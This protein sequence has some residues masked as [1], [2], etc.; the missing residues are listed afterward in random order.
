MNR[1]TI[2]LIALLIV[3]GAIVIFFLPSAQERESSDKNPEINFAIDS[4]SVMKLDMM[5]SGMSLTIENIGG[6]WMITSPGRYPADPLSVTQ[7]LHGLT[8]FKI[9]SIISSNPDKQ[10]LFQVD[11]S[12][13]QIT[14]TERSGKATSL[15]IGKMGPSFTE[16]Y[17]RLPGSRDVYLAEGLDTWS[18]SKELKEWRDKTILSVPSEAVN[19]LTYTIGA[20]QY[21]FRKDSA[22][23]KSGDGAVESN[24]INPPLTSL[25]NLRADDFVDSSMKF[26]NA[27]VTVAV[28]GAE[29]VQLILSPAVS[30][31]SKFFVQVSSS[32]QI[33][34]VSKY[35]AQQ[36]LKPI[37]LHQGQVKPPQIVEKKEPR[38]QPPPSIASVKKEPP[39]ASRTP[40]K[41]VKETE[42]HIQAPAPTEKKETAPSP[43][44]PDLSAAKKFPVKKAV[45]GTGGTT[46]E[47]PSET[48]ASNNIPEKKIEPPVI[49]TEQP[50]PQQTVK[51]SPPPAKAAASST[52]DDGDLTVITVKSGDTMQSIAKKYSV[53]TEQILKWNLLKS[54]TVKP[55]QELY[56]YVKK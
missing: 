11:S 15:I 3:L 52:D 8:K 28:H 5:R 23:W 54:I 29:N 44:R 55:G 14:A 31:S 48:P 32:P 26:Q 51:Q 12:G 50:P 43:Q 40:A 9:G 19:R 56:I 20:R 7:V 53:T 2:V 36:I 45:R 27:P 33:F 10:R 39:K 49:K 30:D 34:V 18:V 37:E 22:G 42:T 16:V 21:E 38:K 4:A 25:S 6:K 1:S 24:I 17:F 46:S 41:S 13:T 35:T 47:P